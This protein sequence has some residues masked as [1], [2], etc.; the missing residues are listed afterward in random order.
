MWR[1]YLWDLVLVTF[2]WINKK[3]ITIIKGYETKNS[4]PFSFDK[5]TKSPIIE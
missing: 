5:F 1:G 4:Y 3:Y 2:L